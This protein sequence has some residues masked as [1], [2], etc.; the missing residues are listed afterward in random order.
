MEILQ[1]II[2]S[3]KNYFVGQLDYDGLEYR[4]HIFKYADGKLTQIADICELEDGE[5]YAA[6]YLN[7][8]K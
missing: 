6:Y 3:E 1:W 4:H 5:G 8:K 2:I 7:D